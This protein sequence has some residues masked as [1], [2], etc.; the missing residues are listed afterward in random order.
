MYNKIAFL[1][2]SAPEGRVFGLDI[3]TAISIGIQLLNG[4]I[5]AVALTFILYKPVKEFMRKRTDRIK[6]KMDN[7]DATM[8]KAND[9]IAEYE[10]KLK[11]IEKERMEL[12][13]AARLKAE[14][15]SK[16][17]L[18]E[19]KKEAYEIKK[20]SLESVYEDKKRLKEE[21][22]LHIIELSSLIAKKYIAQTIDNDT[23]DRLFEEAIAQLEEAQ[24]EN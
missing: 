4:I 24:W 6:N 14:E 9:L 23:Q 19:A 7:A 2:Q 22:R 20:R 10:L 12:L 13:E 8:A 15:E 11:N 3:Q 18:E 21:T 17:I 16:R 1:A 5:L